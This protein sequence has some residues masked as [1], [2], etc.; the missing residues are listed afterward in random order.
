VRFGGTEWKKQKG[1]K[2]FVTAK[3][4][5]KVSNPDWRIG[6]D[7]SAGDRGVSARIFPYGEKFRGV[8]AKLGVKRC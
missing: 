8:R 3:K 1:L 6:G 2:R 5:V 4:L 7:D